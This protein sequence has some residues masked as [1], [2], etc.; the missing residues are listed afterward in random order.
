MSALPEDQPVNWSQVR[1]SSTFESGEAALEALVQLKEIELGDLFTNRDT[2]LDSDENEGI[3]I[4]FF[5]D[6]Q[7]N[8]LILRLTNDTQL[9]VRFFVDNREA[10]LAAELFD[11]ILAVT[12]QLSR[13]ELV[14]SKEFDQPYTSLE[15]PFEEDTELDIVGLRIAEPDGDYIVQKSES[16]DINVLFSDK[17]EA[18]YDEEIPAMFI[19]GKIKEIEEFLHE[20]L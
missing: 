12:E 11:E 9:Q 2:Q 13:D 16:G 5:H 7:P 1:A 10:D 4:T 15:T 14:I 8:S 18:M 19:T 3:S 17:T 20:R 6:E